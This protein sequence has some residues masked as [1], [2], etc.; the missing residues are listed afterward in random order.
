M[1]TAQN[2]GNDLAVVH[3]VVR[4]YG[5]AP[6][7]AFIASYRRHHAGRPHRLILAAK[8]FGSDRAF[9]PWAERLGGIPFELVRVADQGLDIGSYARIAAMMQFERYFFCNSRTVILHDDWLE[10]LCAALDQL[11]GG[12]VGA[13]GSWQSVSSGHHRNLLRTSKWFGPLKRVRAF[14]GFAQR[15]ADYP[16]FPNAHLR[17]NAFLIQRATMMAL[18]VPDISGKRDALRFESGRRSLTRQVQANGAKVGVVDAMGKTHLARE[19]DRSGTFWQ[20]EQADLLIG[21][22][23]TGKYACANDQERRS[24]SA[25]AWKKPT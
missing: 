20:G 4:D 24:L 18:S 6:F 10:Y 19:W 9:G 8:Q 21:D 13:T 1:V 7:D 25:I 11:P 16:G 12:V 22:N 15:W 23:Q 17:T 14:V 5:F 2:L 3:L